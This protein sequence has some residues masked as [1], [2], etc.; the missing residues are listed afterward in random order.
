MKKLATLALIAALAIGAAV[1]AW[2]K[3]PGVPPESGASEQTPQQRQDKTA[4][5][6]EDDKYLLI[7]EWGVRLP[8]S[9][10]LQGDLRYRLT[11]DS[12]DATTVYFK[13]RSLVSSTNGQA[14]D[15]VLQPWGAYTG[16][17]DVYLSRY[18]TG[19][20][21][22]DRGLKL[23]GNFNGYFYYRNTDDNPNISCVSAEF[24]QFGERYRQILNQLV[25]ALDNLEVAD[26]NN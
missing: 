15:I 1:Y 20:P 6:S 16:G 4:G 23:V 7:N 13:S 8:L 18:K 11:T 10:G 14:C 26:Q 2:Q 19:E 17:L 3:E 12:P 22:G 25:E 5:Y 21:A 24:P 9:P